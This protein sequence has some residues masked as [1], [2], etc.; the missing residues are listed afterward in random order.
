MRLG[1]QP[2]EICENVL[3]ILGHGD[4]RQRWLADHPDM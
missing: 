2:R 4:E 1:A 3:E